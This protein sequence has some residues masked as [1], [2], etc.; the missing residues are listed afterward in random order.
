MQRFRL[1]NVLVATAP[2]ELLLQEVVY[3]MPKL[4]AHY[5]WIYH[6]KFLKDM[7]FSEKK[8]TYNILTDQGFAWVHA[9]RL[10]FVDY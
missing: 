3:V 2:A 8:G 1:D 5:I 7:D 4:D 10:F 9:A 6:Q